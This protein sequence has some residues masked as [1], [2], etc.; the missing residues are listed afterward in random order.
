MV[1]DVVGKKVSDS[2]PEPEQ[3]EEMRLVPVG[4]LEDILKEVQAIKVLVSKNF[5]TE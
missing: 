2:K 3:P 5:K 1:E 4:V